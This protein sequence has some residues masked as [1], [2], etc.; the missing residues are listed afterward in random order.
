MDR[1][2]VVT[3]E[4]ITIRRGLVVEITTIKKAE[5]LHHENVFADRSRV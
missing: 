5:S 2:Y 3:R 4:S 1:G